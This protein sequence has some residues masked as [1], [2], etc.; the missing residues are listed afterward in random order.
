LE[1]ELEKLRKLVDTQRKQV[2]E[3]MLSRVEVENR[4]QS[5]REELNLKEQVKHFLKLFRI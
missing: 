1:K 5:L 2:E 4:L 3:E